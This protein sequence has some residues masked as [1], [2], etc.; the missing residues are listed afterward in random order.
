MRFSSIISTRDCVVS[1]DHRE[2]AYD[3]PGGDAPVAAGAGGAGTHSDTY[4]SCGRARKVSGVTRM[5]VETQSFPIE[6][7]VA[8]LPPGR[9]RR[10]G[11][12]DDSVRRHGGAARRHGARRHGQLHGEGI[13]YTAR[14]GEPQRRPP[15]EER[16]DCR[17]SAD[18]EG[19]T[20]DRR[21]R[22]H[23]QLHGEGIAYTAR[24]PESRGAD[25]RP[26]NAS[27]AGPRPTLRAR[28]PTV[29]GGE[30]AAR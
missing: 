21:P 18:A 20:A 7:A 22:R 19:E 3:E 26:K 8:P 12:G 17:A 4:D 15:V 11:V 2:W 13:A 14:A 28:R 16:I 9:H 10:G 30:A 24:V 1:G 6:R 29:A 25:R 27:T 5:I 23:G